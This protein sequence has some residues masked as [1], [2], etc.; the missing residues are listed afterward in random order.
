MC[1]LDVSMPTSGIVAAQQISEALPWMTIIMLTASSDADDLFSALRAGA[2]GYL[3]KGPD[4]SRLGSTLEGTLRGEAA[5]SRT[6]TRK[7]I[8]EFHRRERERNPLLRRRGRR[9]T[10]KEWEVLQLMG[11]GL[12]TR[13]MADRLFVAP[14]TVRTHVSAI[15]RKLRVKSR[16]EL[17]ELLAR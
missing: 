11:E 10:A 14:V 7:V 15:L 4:H 6:L 16:A 13:E 8:A 3:V 1:L 17:L 12:T 2:S 9:L 5:L